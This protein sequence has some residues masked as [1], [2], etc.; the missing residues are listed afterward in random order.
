MRWMRFLRINGVRDH[1][2][3]EQSPSQNCQEFRYPFQ[4]FYLIKA[5]TAVSLKPENRNLRSLLCTHCARWSVIVA[6]KGVVFGFEIAGDGSG[7][8]LLQKSEV[9][10]IALFGDAFPDDGVFVGA[11]TKTIDAEEGVGGIDDATHKGESQFVVGNGL[12]I[13]ARTV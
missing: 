10:E 6:E 3:C 2:A 7:D 11:W 1:P 12:H 13:S 4:G 8:E 5:K 9:V